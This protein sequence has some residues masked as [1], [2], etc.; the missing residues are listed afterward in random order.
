MSTVVS[1]PIVKKSELFIFFPHQLDT[2]A[3]AEQHIALLDLRQRGDEAILCSC[4]TVLAVSTPLAFI[5]R[6]TSPSSSLLCFFAVSSPGDADSTIV[7]LSGD[8]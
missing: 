7:S 1:F 6:I 4:E 2:S 8:D 3:V 5:P